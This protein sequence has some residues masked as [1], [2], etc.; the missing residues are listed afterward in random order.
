MNGLLSPP[1]DQDLLA[2]QE[3]L[4]SAQEALDDLL[5]GPDPDMVD[6][7]RAD[8]TLAEMNVRTAQAAYDKIAWQENVGSSQ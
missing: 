2:A 7:A 1:G 4:K 8:L 5:A 6:I 3:S